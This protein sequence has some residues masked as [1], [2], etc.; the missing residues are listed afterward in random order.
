MIRQDDRVFSKPLSLGQGFA[1]RHRRAAPSLAVFPDPPAQLIGRLLGKRSIAVGDGDH[2]G[3][4]VGHVGPGKPSGDGDRKDSPTLLQDVNSPQHF[5]HRRMRR[6]LARR[7]PEER[8]LMDRHRRMNFAA[9]GPQDQSRRLAA[10]LGHVDMRVGVVPDDRIGQ[11]D[12]QG[13]VIAVE[14]G[15]DDDRPPPDCFSHGGDKIAVG[16]VDLLDHH[17]SVQI[18]QHPVHWPARLLLLP[19]AIEEFGL[20]RFVVAPPNQAAGISEGPQQRNQLESVLGRAVDESAHAGVSA[21]EALDHFLSAIKPES[22]FEVAHG[23][24]RFGEGAGLVQH[25]AGNDS[26][27][28]MLLEVQT[29]RAVGGRKTP[30]P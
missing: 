6:H 9:N 8:K 14:V 12:A 26:H 13:R 29:G 11:G 1:N 24:R 5:V 3:A 28:S 17:R 2:A 4:D 16:I 27:H 15:G 30:G 7:A 22:L 23:R 19:Q 18:E 20:E 10:S 21:A 25:A